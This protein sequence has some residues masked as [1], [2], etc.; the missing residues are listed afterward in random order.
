[1]TKTFRFLLW[2]SGSFRFWNTRTSLLA[3]V[4]LMATL[5]RVFGQP[6]ITTQPHNQSAVVGT[7]ATFTVG[8]S[9]AEPLNYQ[10]RSHLSLSSFT[11]I[12]FGTEAALVLTNVQ[13]TTRRF[14]VVVTD[15]GGLS[16]TSS[17]LVTLTVLLPPSITSQPTNA[18][19]DV[20]GSAT[21]SVGASGAA[22]LTYQWEWN[23]NVLVGQTNRTLL[24]TNLQLTHL[25]QYSVVVSNFIGSATSQMAGLG[26]YIT[27]APSFEP[28]LSI[29]R[30]AGGL[31]VRWQENGQLERASGVTGPWQSLTALSPFTNSPMGAM[32]FFRVKH[33]RPVRVYLPSRYDAQSPAPLIIA[34]HGY[35]PTGGTGVENYFKLQPL[36]ESR[37]FVYCYPDGLLDSSGRRFWNATTT[38]CDYF[39]A[40][41]DDAG[42]LR[43]L[44]EGIGSALAIERKRVYLLGHSNGGFMSYRMACDYADVIAG[45]A[46]LA[47]TTTLGETN[48]RPSQPVNVLHIHGTADEVVPYAGGGRRTNAAG[49]VSIRT[50][51]MQV[52][53]LW[54]GFNGSE[55]PVTDSTPSVDLDLSVAGLDTIVTRYGTHPAGGEVE[56]WSIQNANH[57]PVLSAEFSPRMV[58]WLLARP[59]P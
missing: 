24:L 11:N 13:P 42:Y 32:A 40:G 56:L 59:K 54:A 50:G 22:P 58:D 51:A 8:A 23:T 52:V 55:D 16:V 18:V 41:V 6:V 33:P 47:G 36:A 10:W 37:G 2:I 1:M 35:S 20:G 14:A 29:S 57:F 15:S 44:I 9:G 17:P 28:A 38:C 43:G 12:P 27:M 7:T 21:F 3:V 4:I 46:S 45:I 26:L 19:G 31:A 39:D 30:G 48:C 34:L 53:Q 25:G 5:T 49:V